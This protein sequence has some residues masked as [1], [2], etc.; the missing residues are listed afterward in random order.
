MEKGLG[1][2][3]Q[4]LG[5]VRNRGSGDFAACHTVPV[6]SGFHSRAGSVAHENDER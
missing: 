1:V 2:R 3:G 4:G 5:Q 6:Y